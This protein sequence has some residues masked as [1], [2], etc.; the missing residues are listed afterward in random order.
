[1]QVTSIDT[2]ALRQETA[3]VIFEVDI[4]PESEN[5]VFS[6]VSSD[7][8]VLVACCHREVNG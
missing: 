3:V 5:Y 4:R 1:M 7:V 8:L 2:H 6:N